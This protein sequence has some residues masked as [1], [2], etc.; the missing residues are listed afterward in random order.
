MNLQFGKDTKV[1]KN[2]NYTKVTKNINYTK[3]T[4][5]I[6]YTLNECVV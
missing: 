6:N 3:V 2:I 1:T 5:N 4:K